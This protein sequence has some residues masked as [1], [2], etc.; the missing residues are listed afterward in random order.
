MLE[1]DLMKE[2]VLRR[3]HRNLGILL[4]LFIILQ[5]GTGF[6]ISLGE[7]SAL[8]S[9]GHEDT[10]ASSHGN[11]EGESLWHEGLEFIHHGA[12]TAGS[13]YRILIGIGLLWMAVSGTIIFFKIRT[14]SKKGQPVSSD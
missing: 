3:W 14:R 4:A 8:H 13:L 5:A 10:H 2:S 9:N 12:G 1:N 7:F 11:N 6:L